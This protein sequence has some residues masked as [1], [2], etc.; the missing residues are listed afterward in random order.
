VCHEGIIPS[1]PRG[2]GFDLK[3]TVPR[4]SQATALALIHLP[5]LPE[6]NQVQEPLDRG[7]PHLAGGLAYTSN[8]PIGIAITIMHRHADRSSARSIPPG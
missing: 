1:F 2:F 5:G 6:A 7:K 3:H 8:A 4:Q